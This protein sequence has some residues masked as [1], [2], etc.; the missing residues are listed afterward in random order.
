MPQVRKQADIS[1]TD[2]QLIAIVGVSRQSSGHSMSYIWL[3]L[4]MFQGSSDAAT[5]SS[6]AVTAIVQSD[7]VPATSS[8]G[9]RRG[10]GRGRGRLVEDEVED[11]IV[12]WTRQHVLHHNKLLHH[13]LT[14]MWTGTGRRQRL[15]ER[16]FHLLVH[17][18]LLL[19]L[20]TV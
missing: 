7:T 11:E 12:L 6:S 16:T 5:A 8:D 17:L 10:R 19:L 13:K 4:L 9:V 14:M 20:R 1:D 2:D 18:D 3:W 15:P